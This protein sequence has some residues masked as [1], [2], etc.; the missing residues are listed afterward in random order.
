MRGR[1]YCSQIVNA[2]RSTLVHSLDPHWSFYLQGRQEVHISSHFTLNA[3]ILL[4]RGRLRV[5]GDFCCSLVLSPLVSCFI[6]PCVLSLL[7]FLPLVFSCPFGQSAPPYICSTYVCYTT[8]SLVFLRTN[9]AIGHLAL[10]VVL[11]GFLPVP[12]L[13]LTLGSLNLSI[14]KQCLDVAVRNLVKG[15]SKS[16]AC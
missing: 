5:S 6:F 16:G 4:S 7:Y 10:I 14:S 8:F 15:H 3:L 12:L 11:L 2:L 1:C 9:L 13:D